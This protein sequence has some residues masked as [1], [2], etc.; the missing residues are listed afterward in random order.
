MNAFLILAHPEPHSFNAALFHEAHSAL[1][2]LGYS[3]ATSDL[4]RMNFNPVSDRSNF[5]STANPDFLKLQIEEQFAVANGGFASDLEAEMRKVEAADL[6]V[7]HFPL[8]WFSLPAILKGWVDRIFASGRFYGSGRMY[9][10]GVLSGKKV[11]LTITTGGPGAIYEAD[12]F[13]GDIHAIIKPIHRGIFQFLGCDVLA[14]HIVFS[15]TNLST[16]ERTD[17][18]LTY[19]GRLA[20]LSSEPPLPPQ[21]Y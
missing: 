18:L 15:P 5:T 2:A 20:G 14:P 21:R 10:K 8:W 12:S 1:S 13:H 16:A 7:F 6:L 11:M 3:V 17:A 19:R 4:Y 9:E